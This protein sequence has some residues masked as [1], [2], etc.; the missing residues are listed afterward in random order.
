MKFSKLGRTAAAAA[1]AILEAYSV[2]QMRVDE[3]TALINQFKLVGCTRLES[4]S[5]LSYSLYLASTTALHL[6]D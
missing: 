6:H 4:L 5:I 3:C 2:L 1:V